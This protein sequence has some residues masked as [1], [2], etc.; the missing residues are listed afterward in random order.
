M[1]YW[2]GVSYIVL[3][4]NLRVP[5]D[6]PLTAIGYKYIYRKLLGFIDNEGSG[7]TE[8]GDPYVSCFPEFFSGVSVLPIV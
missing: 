2:P 7:S 4:R 8:S 6:R 5:G 1:K 3:K